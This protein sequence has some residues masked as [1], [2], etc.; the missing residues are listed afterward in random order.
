MSQESPEPQRDAATAQATAA[1]ADQGGLLAALHVKRNVAISAVVG[2]AL[3]GAVYAGRMLEV[4]GPAPQ[5]G[6]PALFAGLALVLAFA[7]TTLLAFVLTVVSA[8]RLAR[9]TA[10]EL[11]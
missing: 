11:E 5:E 8:V 2:L 1:G 10:R 4:F 7:V 9:Q 3:A 6:S